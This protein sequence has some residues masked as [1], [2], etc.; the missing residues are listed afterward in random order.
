MFG[1]SGFSNVLTDWL[2]G[3]VLGIHGTDGSAA[4]LGGRVSHGCIRMHNDD[5]SYLA[6]LLPLGTP[7]TV[8]AS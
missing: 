7:V 6:G 2:G 4:A 5:I 8:L 3:G 1:L